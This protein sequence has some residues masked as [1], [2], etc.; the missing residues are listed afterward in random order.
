[1]RLLGGVGSASRNTARGVDP[2]GMD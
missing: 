2:V 1:L